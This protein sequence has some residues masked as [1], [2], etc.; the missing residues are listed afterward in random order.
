MTIATHAPL[1]ILFRSTLLDIYN[2][3][4]SC[5]TE[6]V[7]PLNTF[8]HIQPWLPMHHWGCCSAQ[9][10][11]TYTTMTAHAPLR[12]FRST[13]LDIYNHDCSCTTEEVAPLNN[14]VRAQCCWQPWNMV[15]NLFLASILNEM[16]KI[17]A[18]R[19]APLHGWK[20][21]P[22]TKYLTHLLFHVN[23]THWIWHTESVLPV[24][25]ATLDLNQKAKKGM[26]KVCLVWAP[27]SMKS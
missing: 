9:R 23:H 24:L 5:T 11:W 14:F 22:T 26:R 25:H 4:C 16:N 1:R 12:M 8:G 20:N 10:F 15:H 17:E 2:H 6:D 19:V 3:D 21:T 13:L 18:C 27:C 7:V